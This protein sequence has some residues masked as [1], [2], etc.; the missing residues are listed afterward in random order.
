MTVRCQGG[1]ATAEDGGAV[2]TA[3]RPSPKSER[4]VLASVLH[5][6]K[7]SHRAGR[8]RRGLREARGRRGLRHP[9][10]LAG[11][12]WAGTEKVF[13]SRASSGFCCAV[14]MFY[15][16]TVSVLVLEVSCGVSRDSPRGRG[17]RW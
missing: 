1:E 8:D 17:R 7:S 14:R 4:P 10:H 12:A 11:E 9:G 13:D 16:G 2:S 6:P 5:L 3:R 15:F